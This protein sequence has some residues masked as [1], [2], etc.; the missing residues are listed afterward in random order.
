MDK[1]EWVQII[2]SERGGFLR[3]ELKP[4]GIVKAFS[5]TVNKCGYL[6]RCGHQTCKYILIQGF[7]RKIRIH[8][9]W[10][11]IKRFPKPVASL[12]DSIQ[13]LTHA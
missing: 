10:E 9:C 2:S 7:T 11:K 4:G 1:G 13:E 3:T 6:D 12:V 8:L 5:S